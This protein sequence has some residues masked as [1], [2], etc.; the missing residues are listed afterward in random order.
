MQ[1]YCNANSLDV[2]FLSNYRDG[3]NEQP[4]GKLE[5]N[6]KG[7]NTDISYELMPDI[8]SGPYTGIHYGT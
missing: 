1:L 2:D 8:G 4:K 6:C 7:K 5:I 3:T